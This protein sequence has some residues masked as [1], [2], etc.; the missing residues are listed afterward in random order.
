MPVRFPAVATEIKPSS[1]LHAV[2]CQAAGHPCLVVALRRCEA[3][4]G[5]AYHERLVHCQVLEA[6][7]VN[8]LQINL[9]LIC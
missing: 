2:I 9:A 7:I 8:Y 6:M 5:S 1:A 4:F 3:F